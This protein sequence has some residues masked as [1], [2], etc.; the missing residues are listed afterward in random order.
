VTGSCGLAGIDV[1]DTV[2]GEGC[3]GRQGITNY[4]RIGGREVETMKGRERISCKL[5][6]AG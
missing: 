5:W 2:W 3:E 4:R 6:S 1:S